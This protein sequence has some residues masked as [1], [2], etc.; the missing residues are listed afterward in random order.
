MAR[1]VLRADKPAERL[2]QAGPNDTVVVRLS[3][4]FFFG[5]CRP[6]GPVEDGGAGPGHLFQHHAAQRFSRNVHAVAQRIG[7][8]CSRQWFD[9]R[10]FF[11][12][13]ELRPDPGA[14][15]S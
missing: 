5:R 15:A 11:S 13:N 14:A 12:L 2:R 8:D 4:A 1:I 9:G 10:G 6:A 7:A 3:A